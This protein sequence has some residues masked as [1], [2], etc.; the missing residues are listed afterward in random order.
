ML[1][2]HSLPTKLPGWESSRGPAAIWHCDPLADDWDQIKAHQGLR[3]LSMLSQHTEMKLES[4][5]SVFLCLNISSRVF[6]QDIYPLI[7]LCMLLCFGPIKQLWEVDTT[8][9]LVYFR[10]EHLTHLVDVFCGCNLLAHLFPGFSFFV[11]CQLLHLSHIWV[12]I[13][14]KN[15]ATLFGT[16]V[17]F[18]FVQFRQAFLRALVY[19][20]RGWYKISWTDFELMLIYDESQPYEKSSW[21]EET[22]L[23]MKQSSR[24]SLVFL[25]A[26]SYFLTIL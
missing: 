17:Y 5:A 18:I 2:A 6:I 13:I 21:E 11:L 3:L 14:H 19:N 23:G 25:S 8:S 15:N 16:E 20:A 22:A 9:F 26:L 1:T 4:F 7:F 10:A 24:F 12:I